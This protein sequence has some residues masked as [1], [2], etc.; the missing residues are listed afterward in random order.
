MIEA[1]RS[2]GVSESDLEKITYNNAKRV[3]GI[4]RA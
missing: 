2:A 4:T 1:I 3:F